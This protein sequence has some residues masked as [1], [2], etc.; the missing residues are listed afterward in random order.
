MR[1]IYLAL[2]LTSP[3]TFSNDLTSLFNNSFKNS[4]LAFIQSSINPYTNS[5]DRS[6]GRILKNKEGA[7]FYVDH[8]FKEKYELTKDEIIITDIELNQ[9]SRMQLSDLE[10]NMLIDILLNGL[11]V[12]NSSYD[13]EFDRDTI[14][15]KSSLGEGYNQ[16]EVKFK[17]NKIYY[18]KYNDNLNIENL[19]MFKNLAVN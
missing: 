3:L 19:I 14:F 18:L 16:I 13:L 2:L 7:I 10:D 1:L 6:E 4:S 8:P 12:N 9:T 11:A 5:I 15:I 17:E